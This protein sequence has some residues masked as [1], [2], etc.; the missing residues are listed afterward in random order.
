MRLWRFLDVD[1]DEQSTPCRFIGDLHI[2]MSHVKHTMNLVTRMNKRSTLRIVALCI[3][4]YRYNTLMQ[5][6]FHSVD[7]MVASK[8]ATFHFVAPRIFCIQ[9]FVLLLSVYTFT[10]EARVP[11]VLI[12]LSRFK[13]IIDSA[14]STFSHATH[15][16]EGKCP[17]CNRFFY[18]CVCAPYR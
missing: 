17:N 4:V 8:Q 14:H 1:L 12:R 13:H 11:T 16:F 7:N 9:R 6:C 15:A 18:L 2:R 3:H 10:D 5:S